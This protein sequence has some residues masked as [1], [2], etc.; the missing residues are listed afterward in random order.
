KDVRLVEILD[1]G[2][3]FI[4]FEYIPG[5]NVEYELFD[6]ILTRES[7]SVTNLIDRIFLLIDGLSSQRSENESITVKNI[8][9]IYGSLKNSKKY[10]SPGIV[11]LNLD[12]FILESNGKIVVFDYE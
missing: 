1:S 2:A 4:E 12:N 7:E 3:G 9:D 10:A 11:D 6:K 5:R 8:N